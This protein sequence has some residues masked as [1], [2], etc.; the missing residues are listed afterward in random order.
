MRKAIFLDRDGTINREVNYLY[1]VSDFEFISGAVD[2]IKIFHE[3]GYIVIVITNQAGIARGYYSQEDVF[4]LHKYIDEQLEKM[5]TYID[6]YY[7][8]PHHPE[9]VISEYARICECRKPN[10]GM[11]KRAVSDFKEKGISICLKDSIII[12]DKEIDIETGRKA[13]IGKCILV[14]SGHKVDEI[15]TAADK[16]Y[17]NMFEFAVH[18]AKQ[19]IL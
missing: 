14:R 10:I 6:A 9:G 13:Q 11:I 18:M 3:L 12:G 8:C 19:N 16:V 4:S 7:F 15:K 1:K 5:G 17:D 2:A